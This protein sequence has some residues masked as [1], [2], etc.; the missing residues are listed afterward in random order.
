MEEGDEM[1][2]NQ[3]Y[4]KIMDYLNANTMA[5]VNELVEITSSSA[6]TIRRDLTYLEEKGMLERIHGGATISQIEREEDYGEK[7]V[8]NLSKKIKIAQK[9]ASMIEEGDI[10]FI[11]A[12]TTTY[13]MVPFIS[14]QNLTIVTNGITLIEQLVRN[15]HQ[16]HVLG[17]RIKPV[18]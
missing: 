10:I 2:T 15:G 14:Q 6:P 7:S 4:E 16:V 3:R 8:R 5:S 17:G 18:T 1:L 12:G 9:A 13:E 11:D